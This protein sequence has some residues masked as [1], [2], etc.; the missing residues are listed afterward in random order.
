MKSL[1]R[2]L[3][4]AL[5]AAPLALAQTPTPTKAPGRAAGAFQPA[6]SFTG[7]QMQQGRVKTDADWNEQVETC[8]RENAS[9]KSQLETL[10]NENAMLRRRLVAPAFVQ[11]P[12]PK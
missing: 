8:K 3:A 1:P 6:K 4:A 10:R 11:T 5:F 7:V 12:A 9:L 2:A